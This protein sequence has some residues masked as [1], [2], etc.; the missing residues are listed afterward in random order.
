MMARV[1]SLR[2]L[3]LLGA[4]A[5]ASV[6]LACHLDMLLQAK[7]A[8]RAALTITPAEI[9]DS[10]RAGSSD[11]RHA[12]VQITNSGD[13]NL[14][15]SANNRSP[16]IHLDP[17]DGD[18]PGTLSISLDPEDLDAGVYQSE[19]TVRATSTASADTETKTIPVTF[20]I[21][22]PGLNVAPTSIERT[23]TLNSN[24]SFS[25]TLQISN[26]G[27]GELNWTAS[28]DKSWI[29]LG[30]TSGSGNGSIPVTI[31]S[32]G[33]TG[34]IYHGTITITAP[35]AEGSPARV[36]VTLNVLAPSLAVSP[37]FL[38]E[39]AVA[40]STILEMD[41][42]HITNSG[43]GTITWT[44]TKSAL[45]LSL[46]KTSGG[47]PDDVVATM[48]PTGL[49]PGLYRDTVVFTSP[50]ATNKTVRLG[51]EFSITQ[52]GLSVTPSSITAT[53]QQNDGKKKVDL[54]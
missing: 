38:R 54:S 25:E 29:A 23:T 8:A 40:G 11:L 45:W 1:R 28:D 32:S 31:S 35:G 50:E 51:V 19:V 17:T 27:T 22:K 36:A 52:P 6:S 49:P 10:A 26:H 43:N 5:L 33:L 13:G 15:W 20:L 2:R 4:V 46:S 12:E 37:G 41:T 7:K 21:Q 42:L 53:A 48:N 24:E 3:W 30:A 34:G 39:T 16:W 9:R 44:A 14:K 18:V 47:A